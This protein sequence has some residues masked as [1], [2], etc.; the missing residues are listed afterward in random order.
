MATDVVR[1]EQRA[2]AALRSRDGAACAEAASAY[3]G[4]LLPQARYEEW[5]QARRDQLRFRYGELLRLSG[6]WER[7][8]E[9]D[10][11]DEPAYRELIRATL[12]EG[13]RHP[14]IRWY[15]RLRTHLEH[16]FGVPPSPQTESL[17]AECVAALEPASTAFIGRQVELARAAAALAAAERGE[18]GALAP[19][20]ESPT[21]KPSTSRCP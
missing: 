13:N 21:A 20:S 11:A 2:D 9:V 7:L 18:L 4:E 17:H 14:A 10:P 15:G 16:E 6:Q 5:T 19:F 12:T 1:F 8:V 3:G